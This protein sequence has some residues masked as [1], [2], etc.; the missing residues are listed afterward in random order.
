MNNILLVAAGVCVGLAIYHVAFR[1]ENTQERLS[2]IPWVSY[3]I[4]ELEDSHKFIENLLNKL[5]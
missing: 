1:K 5:D 2:A 3:D 4:G